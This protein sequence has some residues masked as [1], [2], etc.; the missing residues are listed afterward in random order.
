MWANNAEQQIRCGFCGSEIVITYTNIYNVPRAQL[1][2]RYFIFDFVTFCSFL[3]CWFS[4]AYFNFIYANA[5]LR[6]KRICS[7]NWKLT[8]RYISMEE[9]FMCLNFWR[10]RNFHHTP[11]GIDTSVLLVFLNNSRFW[12]CKQSMSVADVHY[13]WRVCIECNFTWENRLNSSLQTVLLLQNHA[14]CASLGICSW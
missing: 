10:K 4:F 14:I 12:N 11:F 3:F 7:I 9:N 1:L 5:A 2:F 6:S 8:A 13:D